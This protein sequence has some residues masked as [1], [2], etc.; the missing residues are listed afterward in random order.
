MEENYI[1]KKQL[2]EKEDEKTREGG[3]TNKSREDN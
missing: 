3:V 1:S 2:W